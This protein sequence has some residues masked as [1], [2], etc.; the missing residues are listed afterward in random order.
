MN[1]EIA[2]LMYHDVTDDPVSSGFY[3]PGAT[4][5]RLSPGA[6][7][8]HLTAIATA[9][10]PPELVTQASFPP[11]RRHLLLT[12]DDGGKSAVE[13]G[14]G[15]ECRGWRGHFFVVTGLIGTPGFLTAAEIRALHTAGH[16]IG[17]HSV[18]HP[19]IFYSLPR[20]RMHDEWHRSRDALSDILG[21]PCLAASLPGGDLSPP[22]SQTAADAGYRYLFTSEPCVQ[23]RRVDDCW[24][25][26]RFAVRS[27][28]SGDRV[29]ELVHFRGWHRALLW[30]RLKTGARRALPPLYRWYVHQTTRS[31][32]HPAPGAAR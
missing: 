7:T 13:I 4:P 31:H 8:A 25:L 20:W 29:R 12:F 5:F 23:A 32:R 21:E 11:T 2:T 26:G 9:A 17:S 6:F 19:D 16:L 28:T 3:R 22:A 1:G 15:L 10:S 30:R 24:V 27:G 18:T 14:A